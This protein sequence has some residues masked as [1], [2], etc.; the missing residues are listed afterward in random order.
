MKRKG[1]KMLTHVITADF[2]RHRI[3]NIVGAGDVE[4]MYDGRRKIAQTMK[5]SLK[6]DTVQMNSKEDN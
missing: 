5:Y 1:R 6:S 4:G 2:K 3:S